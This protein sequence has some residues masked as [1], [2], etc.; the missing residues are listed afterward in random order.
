MCASTQK[1][2]PCTTLIKISVTCSYLPG[3]LNYSPR[4]TKNLIPM[5]DPLSSCNYFTAMTIQ[6]FCVR[7][8]EQVPF[9]NT[10]TSH[11]VKSFGPD[12]DNTSLPFHC[13]TAY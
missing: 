12:F 9:L 4:D 5:A 13:P 3:G 7:N 8:P 10:G 11:L 1:I 6:K 2:T